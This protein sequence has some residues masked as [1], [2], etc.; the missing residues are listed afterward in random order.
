MVEELLRNRANPNMVRLYSTPKAMRNYL[1]PSIPDKYI[2]R[3]V[4]V[5]KIMFAQGQE[6]P[7]MLASS[8]ESKEIAYML[9]EH[10]ADPD[11]HDEVML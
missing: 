5:A 11:K 3:V 6:P 10:G 4:I 1:L 2:M 9:L 8:M 7:L